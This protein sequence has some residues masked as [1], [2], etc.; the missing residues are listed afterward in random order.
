[1]VTPETG[2][3]SPEEHIGQRIFQRIASQ[4][5]VYA[6]LD[7]LEKLSRLPVG[8]YLTL[9]G[10]AALH[11]VYLHGRLIQ[12]LDFYAPSIIALRFGNL[13]QSSRLFV[14]R[15]EHRNR[16]SFTVSGRS[17]P[18]VTIGINII[19]KGDTSYPS[20]RHLFGM[21]K[22]A[23][24]S[25][26]TLPLSDLLSVKLIA[27][28]EH[29]YAEDFVDFWLGL[30][31][32]PSLLEK[33]Q[34]PENRRNGYGLAATETKQTFGE[35]VLSKSESLRDVWHERLSRTL[36]PVPSLEQVQQDLR[37][38]MSSLDR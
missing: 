35:C 25:V 11:G 37:Q 5:Y 26:R 20:E 7:F 2:T 10:E 1:M 13:A 3:I 18:E 22:G 29:G 24:L 27:M 6:Q 38:W 34:L 16:Y 33:I 17:I 36:Y 15:Q 14:A 12:D 9:A 31:S 21:P 8:Q 23:A 28:S 30:R 4:E 19:S 32:D